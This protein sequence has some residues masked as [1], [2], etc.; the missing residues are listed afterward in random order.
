MVIFLTRWKNLGTGPDNDLHK[1]QFGD[2][3]SI[4]LRVRAGA[5]PSAFKS[6]EEFKIDS[7]LSP[8]SSDELFQAQRRGVSV[9]DGTLLAQGTLGY[10]MKL[11]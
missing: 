7:L 9:H 2:C 10:S 3:S 6:G 8:G 11:R 1:R 4:T 5:L